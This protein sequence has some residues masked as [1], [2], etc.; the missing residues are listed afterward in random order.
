MGE[1]E[2]DAWKIYRGTNTK[3]PVETNK[4]IEELTGIMDD[5]GSQIAHR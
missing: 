1:G 2:G 5:E 4:R 3:H